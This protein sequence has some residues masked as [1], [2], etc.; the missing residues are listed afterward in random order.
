MKISDRYKELACALADDFVDGLVEGLDFSNDDPVIQGKVFFSNIFEKQLRKELRN[1][2]SSIFN[3]K[4]IDTSLSHSIKRGNDGYKYYNTKNTIFLHLKKKEYIKQKKIE[5]SSS[6][7]SSDYSFSDDEPSP[8]PAKSSSSSL[9]ELD[10]E[11]LAS[12]E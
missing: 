3:V 6:S 5:S 2:P 12:K 10:D 11:C 4:N 1:D 7:S 8:L 9:V